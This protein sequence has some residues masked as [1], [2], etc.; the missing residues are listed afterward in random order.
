MKNILNKNLNLK[1]KK[2]LLRVDLNVPVLNGKV[3][4]DSRIKSVVPSI[5]H[6]INNRG[7]VVLCSHFGRPGGEENKKYSTCDNKNI[8]GVI[9]VGQISVT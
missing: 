7:K 5:K 2:V 6:I 1:G 9:K 8:R 4:D 3:Q